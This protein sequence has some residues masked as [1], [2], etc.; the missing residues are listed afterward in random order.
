M[1]T[2]LYVGNL[3]YQTTD[4]SLSELFAEVGTVTSAQVV[5]DKYTGQSR[6]FGF[7]EMATEDEAGQAITAIN[8]RNVDGRPLPSTRPARVRTS[9]GGVAATAAA[10]VIAAAVAAAAG[11]V[12]AGGSYGGG[13]GGAAAAA[14]AATAAAAAA[15][16][17]SPAAMLKLWGRG[18]PIERLI[19]YFD[20][21]H[22]SPIMALLIGHGRSGR[23]IAT[24]RPDRSRHVRACPTIRRFLAHGCTQR[25]PL[26]PNRV[27]G[28][29][30]TIPRNLQPLSSRRRSRNT[31]G[32][33][34]TWSSCD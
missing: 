17:G 5:T 23:S 27:P 6:G 32:A 22:V 18:A 7:V 20:A 29:E 25:R 4:E 12:A 2:K 8:G 28:A 1:A 21:T 26:R 30:L 24:L 33:Q 13:G 3:S 9:S 11:A 15:T 10:A 14:A 16:A 19:F 34:I 31:P